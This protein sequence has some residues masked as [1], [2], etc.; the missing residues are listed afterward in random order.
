MLSIKCCKYFPRTKFEVV[1]IKTSLPRSSYLFTAELE[2]QIPKNGESYGERPF[3]P[4]WERG[5]G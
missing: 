1:S 5:G 3:P 4:E 2:F